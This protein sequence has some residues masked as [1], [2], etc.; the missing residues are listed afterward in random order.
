VRGFQP[1]RGLVSRVRLGLLRCHAWQR[2]Y[3]ATFHQFSVLW[4][5]SQRRGCGLLLCGL[6]LART[7]TL[8][9]WPPS[10]PFLGCT[11][12]FCGAPCGHGL[13]LWG[14]PRSA[15]ATEG[16]AGA[17]ACPRTL[18]LPVLEG[19]WPMLCRARSSL[20]LPGLTCAY[21][22]LPV[23]EG[24]WPMLNRAWRTQRSVTA[25]LWSSSPVAPVHCLGTQFPKACHQH[26]SP[27]PSQGGGMGGLWGAPQ[28]TRSIC[29]HPSC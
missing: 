24:A 6:C 25:G 3:G 8:W 14:C 7:H 1:S 4:P 29:A 5:C 27:I 26:P 23:L 21:L 18:V 9:P 12:C 11:L 17:S 16:M 20:C 13:V 2:G 22:V 15:A 10:W 19:A 28:R